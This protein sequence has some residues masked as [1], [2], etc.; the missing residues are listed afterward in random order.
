MCESTKKIEIIDDDKYNL[1]S[2]VTMLPSLRFM[3]DKVLSFY[4]NHYAQQLVKVSCSV[5]TFSYFVV[6]LS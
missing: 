6:K 3:V 4:M 2:W 1:L 5:M